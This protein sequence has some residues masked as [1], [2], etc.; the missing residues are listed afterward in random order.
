MPEDQKGL[1][2]HVPKPD[3]PMVIDD[4]KN[5]LYV[6]DLQ[7]EL[8]ESDD[9]GCALTFLPGLESELS[10]TNI[11][12][13]KDKRPCSEIILYREPESLSIPKGEDNVRRALL[14]TR[15]RARLSRQEPQSKMQRG[16]CFQCAS[17][18]ESNRCDLRCY[19]SNSLGEMM[20]ID[21][22]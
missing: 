15:E 6:H 5:T 2:Q 16:E 10:L 11:M 20:D 12:V 14:E 22:E 17:K 1:A 21:E 19:L 18:P 7:H 3:D 4:T 9:S 13:P 8:A